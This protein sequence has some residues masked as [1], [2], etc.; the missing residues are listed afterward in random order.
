MD[1]ASSAKP[2]KMKKLI[3]LA[4][5][6]TPLLS[7]QSTC[8]SDKLPAKLLEQLNSA[9]KEMLRALSS[10]DSSAFKKIAGYDYLDINA[11]GTKKTLQAMLVDIPSFK[12]MSV[13]FSDQSQRVYGS[14]VLRNGRARF[15][16]GDQVVGEVLYTQGWVYRDN[17]WQFVHWQGTVTKDFLEGKKQ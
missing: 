13:N 6:L 14:F 11:D 12:G 10:G 3:L 2:G 16:S 17:K 9:E 7:I 15:F 1:I 4:F 8:Q 5:L